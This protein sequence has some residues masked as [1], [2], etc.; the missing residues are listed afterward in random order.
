[1]KKLNYKITL[2]VYSHY[3]HYV[4]KKEQ[5]CYSNISLAPKERAISGQKILACLLMNF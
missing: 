2:T 1:M 5:N 4:L 3:T